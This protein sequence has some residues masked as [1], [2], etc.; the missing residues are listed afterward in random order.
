M[1]QRVHS[2]ESAQEKNAAVPG[3]LPLLHS[4]TLTSH[5]LSKADRFYPGNTPSA[6]GVADSISQFRNRAIFGASVVVSGET[7]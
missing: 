6:P 4:V 3:V 5:V 1:M 2:G 7:T